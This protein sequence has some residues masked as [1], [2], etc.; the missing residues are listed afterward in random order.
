MNTQRAPVSAASFWSPRPGRRPRDRGRGR[1]G[2]RQRGGSSGRCSCRC[3]RLR[4]SAGSSWAPAATS[5]SFQLPASTSL[6]EAD[7]QARAVVAVLHLDAALVAVNAQPQLVH[8]AGGPAAGVDHAERAVVEI[9]R[10]GEAVIGVELVFAD[11]SPGGLVEG[12]DAARRRGRCR[13]PSHRWRNRGCGRRCRRARPWSR[14][15]S[16]AA[17]ASWLLGAPVAPGLADQPA[18]QVAGL[19]VADLADLAGCD[20]LRAPSAAPRRCGR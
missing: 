13:G 12:L 7:P 2:C 20:H 14:A 4:R 1:A 10:H 19:D 9:R 11:R 3:G 15:S 18:L 8:V 6:A 16:T 17:T 5:I